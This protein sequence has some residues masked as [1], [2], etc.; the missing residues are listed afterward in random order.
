VRVI[1]RY[2]SQG[3]EAIPVMRHGKG[4]LQALSREKNARPKQGSGSRE[5]WSLV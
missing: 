4:S 5:F 1:G 2:R 3:E